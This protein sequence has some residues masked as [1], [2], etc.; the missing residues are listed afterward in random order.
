[1]LLFFLFTCLSFI[2]FLKS[3]PLKS[4]PLWA[5]EMTLLS[6]WSHREFSA[7][8]I[9]SLMNSFC[10]SFIPRTCSKMSIKKINLSSRVD[11]VEIGEKSVLDLPELVLECILEKLPPAELFNMA[12]VCSSLRNRCVSDHLWERHMRQKWGRV[13]GPAAYR[14]WKWYIATRRDIGNLKQGNQ[15]GLARLLIAVWPLSWTNSKL[16]NSE[17]QRIPLPTDSIMSWYLALETGKFCFPAQV[18]NRENGHV[19][20]MLS[21]YDAELSYDSQT[22]TFQARY[23]PHGRRAGAIESNVTWDRLRAQPVDAPPH[24]LHISDCLNDLQPG[25][26]IEI[27]WRRNEEFPYGWWYGVVGHLESCD[28]N[29]NYCR[30]HNSDTVMLEF[31]Q[32]APGSRWRHTAINRRNHR[33]EGNEADGFYGGIRK[34]KTEREISMWKSLWPTEV[35]E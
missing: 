20:F 31:R 10:R 8:C 6:L 27:Q 5:S 19:G 33:E 35:L 13:I 25:D 18:Y 7:F 2:L 29:A 24:D 9:S 14:Q 16:D 34:L 28:G 17:K 4:L 11:N 1:M 22:D 12:G 21:C 30:C 3:L 32:Y 26:H 23:P 15:S